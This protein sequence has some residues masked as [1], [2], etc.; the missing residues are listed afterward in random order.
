MSAI[1]FVAVL[2]SIM[3]RA[4]FIDSAIINYKYCSVDVTFRCHGFKDC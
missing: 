3:L 4:C 2:A 1:L